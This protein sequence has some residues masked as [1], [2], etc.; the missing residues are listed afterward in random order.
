M[1]GIV[2]DAGNALIKAK[3]F[4]GGEIVFPHAFTELSEAQYL[5]IIHSY[6]SGGIP[7]DYMRLNNK[8]YAVG[9]AAERAG[10]QQHK[11][12]AGRYE[13]GYVGVLA[14]AAIARSYAN[15]CELSVFISHPPGDIN[16]IDALLG[17]VLG[18]W[19]VEICNRRNVYQ[20]TYANC[21]DEPTGGLMNVILNDA[22]TAYSKHGLRGQR[23]LVIDIGGGTTDFIVT[24]ETGEIDYGLARSIPVGIIRV[25]D[26]FET[27][28]RAR[29]K[30]S[31]KET[32][33]LNQ[34]RVR[35]AIRIGEFR[36]GGHVLICQEEAAQAR[37]L[38]VNLILRE[39]QSRYGGGFNFDG[40]LLTGGGAGLLW[41]YIADGLN[42]DNL[43]LADD[44]DSIHL[45]N[46][47]G[48]LK[49]WR[50]YKTIGVIS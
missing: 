11:R 8:C 3:V 23:L 9:E 10:I 17:A 45:A 50:L 20:V 46:V 36:G 30:E 5:N 35:D 24:T 15:S 44:P 38:L 14:A 12:G 25:I 1:N 4:T 40:I 49:L 19:E 27:S 7:A 48:G 22:G 28:F 47:R 33:S 31:T 41:E 39:V 2:I 42:N 37:N 43:H 21:Y 32:Q 18:R 13:R 29:Y 6:G 26:Q 34:E 16:H